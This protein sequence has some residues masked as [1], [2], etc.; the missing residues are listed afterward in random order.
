MPNRTCCRS[1]RHC[2]PPNGGELGWCQLR[3]LSIHP[4]LAAD[5]WC[6]HWMARLPRLPVVTPGGRG[7]P[8][9]SPPANHQLSLS[10]VLPEL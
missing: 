3:Q 5:L 1:C 8:E 6:H 10:A 2:L 7:E 4:E 9:S